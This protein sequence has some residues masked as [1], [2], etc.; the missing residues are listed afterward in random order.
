MENYS[1]CAAIN[2]QIQLPMDSINNLVSKARRRSSSVGA[3]LPM[4]SIKKLIAKARRRSSTMGAETSRPVTIEDIETIRPEQDKQRQHSPEVVNPEQCDHS[5]HYP[6]A[7]SP[8]IYHTLSNPTPPRKAARGFPIA[9]PESFTKGLVKKGHLK[10]ASPNQYTSSLNAPANASYR[11]SISISTAT[12]NENAYASQREGTTSPINAM[13][14]GGVYSSSSTSHSPT[15]AAEE[16]ELPYY[17]RESVRA[18]TMR[19]TEGSSSSLDKK[20]SSAQRR[21]DG[22]AKESRSKTGALR[23]L[24]VN[25][26][27]R[28]DDDLPFYSRESVREK[29]L[30][31]AEGGRRVEE[32]WGGSQR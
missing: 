30:R 7:C 29:T 10:V 22:R 26:R 24:H 18:K 27:T 8:T 3:S 23:E 13:R 9:I 21:V 17:S 14:V 31:L 5:T 16:D 28:L 12:F 25:E 20:C 32:T 15:P 6:Y 11:L 4:R 2:D 1:D 19:L